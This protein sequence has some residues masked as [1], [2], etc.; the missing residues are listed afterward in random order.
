MAP[1]ATNVLAPLP[2]IRA[3]KSDAKRPFGFVRSQCSIGRRKLDNPAGQN[4]PNQKPL[5][6]SSVKP[7]SNTAD[8]VIGTAQNSHESRK[9]KPVGEISERVISDSR[10]Q[11]IEVV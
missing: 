11:V 5:A 7:D 2:A 6:V 10:E 3:Q 8:S 9:A 4:D 1:A